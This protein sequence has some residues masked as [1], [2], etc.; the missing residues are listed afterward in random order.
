M[1]L[2]HLRYFVAV[3]HHRSFTQA[4]RQHHVAQPSLSQQIRRLEEELGAPLFDR[5]GGRVRLTP[6]G[7]AFLPRAERALAEIELGVQ[8]VG[9]FLGLRRGRVVVGTTAISGS[10]ILPPV[11]TEFRRRYPGVNVVLREEGSA[12]LLDLT[13]RGEIDLSL[14]TYRAG[15]PE[16]EMLPLFTE[17]LLLAVPPGH[18][19]ASAG[20]VSL[21][22]VAGEPFVL[23]KEGMGLRS[24]I[25]AVCAAAGFSPQGVF[26]STHMDTVQALVALGMGV[27][28]VP[29]MT[30]SPNKA[31]APV[32]LELAAPR[33]TRTL[34][35][36]W[37]RDRHSPQAA[38]AFAAV[39]QEIW[40]THEPLRPA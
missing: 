2:H 17:D 19:L 26:E 15:N 14:V 32:F 23:L 9:E 12:V 20:T 28:L 34:A 27:A 11:L 22:A 13:C 40:A 8:E 16:L 39:A 21:S 3:A 7:E 37:L 4:A 10:Y 36:A 31:G 30:A 25:Q 29:R 1:E 5:A 6:V 24:V 33:P 38:R 18:P 35:L